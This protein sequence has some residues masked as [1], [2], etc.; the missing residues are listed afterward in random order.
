MRLRV[1]GNR[2]AQHVRYVGVRLFLSDYH[3]RA[4]MFRLHFGFW[5]LQI[6][7]GA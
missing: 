3:G 7:L 6:W 2:L 5:W 4:K 1:S